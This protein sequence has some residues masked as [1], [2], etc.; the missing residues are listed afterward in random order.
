MPALVIGGTTIP[1]E[2]FEWEEPLRIGDAATA[3]DGT[4]LSTTDGYKARG[5]G[6]TAWRDTTDHA[7]LVAVLET[8]GAQTLSGDLAQGVTSVRV[9]KGGTRVRYNGSAAEFST[10]FRLTES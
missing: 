1:A 4:D 6:R 7:T 5:R 3:I 9:T 8:S 2:E 10:A